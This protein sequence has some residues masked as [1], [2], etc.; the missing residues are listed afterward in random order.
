MIEIANA[1]GLLGGNHF[2]AHV[3]E[4][5]G[6]ECRHAVGSVP[7]DGE[8]YPVSPKLH[9][10]NRQHFVLY[11][12]HILRN[13]PGRSAADSSAEAQSKTV[14]GC[15]MCLPKSPGSRPGFICPGS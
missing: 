3:A 15:Q 4:V 10:L 13:S 14:V 5:D 9:I 2:V 6:Y 11:I 7:Y 1:V 8:S 12:F